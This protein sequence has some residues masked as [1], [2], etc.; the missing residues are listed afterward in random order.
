MVGEELCLLQGGRLFRNY[1][2]DAQSCLDFPHQIEVYSVV[3]FAK[4][5]L[6][7]V[8]SDGGLHHALLLKFDVR[9]VVD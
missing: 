1:K 5:V 9:F 2:V 6:Q 8:D 7:Q 3:E 4:V